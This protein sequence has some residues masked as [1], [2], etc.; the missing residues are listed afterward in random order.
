VRDFLWKVV[1]GTLDT[2]TLVGGHINDTEH[3]DFR[4][5]ADVRLRHTDHCLDFIRQAIQC[6]GDITLEPAVLGEDGQVSS[7][8]FGNARQCRNWDFVW[9]FAAQH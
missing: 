8:V 6:A 3:G 4:S 9:T 7:V 2:K 1:L 5:N